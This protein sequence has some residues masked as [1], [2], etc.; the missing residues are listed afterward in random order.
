MRILL[1]GLG[2]FA[3]SILRYWVSGFVQRIASPSLFPWGTLIVNL[4][5]CLLIGIL[6]ELIAIRGRVLFGPEAYPLL[7]IG[8]LGGFTT[9]STFAN[10]TVNTLRNG[11]TAIAIMNIVASLFL[12]LVGVWTGRALIHLF[13]GH[14][15]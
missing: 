11:L 3:G 10:E 9:F 15:K 12:G 1:I 7:V 13:L 6:S 5:G 8:L 14:L 2:G 4:T